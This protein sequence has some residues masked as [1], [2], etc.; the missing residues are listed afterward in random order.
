MDKIEQQ[1]LYKQFESSQKTMPGCD[2]VY[3]G[4][5]TAQDLFLFFMQQQKPENDVVVGLE[6]LFPKQELDDFLTRMQKTKFSKKLSVADDGKIILIKGGKK[7][8]G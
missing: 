4:K 2:L 8:D 3:T 5:S 6:L 1:H 7:H